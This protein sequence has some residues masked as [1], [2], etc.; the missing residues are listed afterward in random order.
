MN[1]FGI[2]DKKQMKRAC[3]QELVFYLGNNT[4]TNCWPSSS[5]LC[6]ADLLLPT[7]KS[8]SDKPCW[9]WVRFSL[10]KPQFCLHHSEMNLLCPH[11][12][13][14]YATGR[15]QSGWSCLHRPGCASFRLI[16]FPVFIVES[17]EGVMQLLSTHKNFTDHGLDHRAIEDKHNPSP[18][19]KV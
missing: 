4:R 7:E 8:K 12:L 5:E 3:A 19:P 1:S 9:K 11:W 14:F 13:E 15:W 10:L 2:M 16:P 18:T 6:R 17:R